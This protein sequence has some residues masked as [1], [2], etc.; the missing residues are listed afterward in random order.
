MPVYTLPQITDTV[1]TTFTHTWYEIRPQA[2][3]NIL[4]ATVIWALLK[5]KGCFKKQVGG[6]F[7]ER[8]IRYQLPVPVMVQKGDILGEGETETETAAFWTW[9]YV[10]MPVQRSIFDD[11]QN[12]GPSMIKPYIQSRI[13]AAR[14]GLTQFHESALWN[15]HDT[16][17]VL[18]QFQGLNDLVPPV[19]S[20]NSGT[21]GKIARPTTYTNDVPT[22]GNTFWSPKYKQY[23][24]TIEQVLVSDMNNLYNTIHNQQIPPD[25]IITDQA[26]YE[27]YTE[28]GLDATQ[29]VMND[30]TKRLLDLGFDVIQFRGKPM[31]YTP[32]IAVNN[33]LMLTSQFID[34]V[35]DPN[36]WMAMTEWK[37]IAKQG[38]RL[39]HI[40]S[41][42]NM[43]TDQPRRH[44]R[45]YV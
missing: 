30:N 35:Y 13:T 2:T 4:N 31:V 25:I 45:L 10:S 1:D 21:Y 9:R 20:R 39:A 28:Y 38:E 19:A 29:I 5:A 6:R 33:I 43:V 16:T 41:A 3:D 40:L 17:E 18:K 44:G 23:S 26:T 32:N 34:V 12:S 22:V 11:Q 27:L 15:A 14:D 24:G 36:M 7:I 37:P 8:T 42:M